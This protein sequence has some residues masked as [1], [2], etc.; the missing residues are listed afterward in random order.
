MQKL[1]KNFAITEFPE[2]GLFAICKNA[3]IEIQAFSVTAFGVG[4]YDFTK[5]LVSKKNQ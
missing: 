3:L 5:N 4:L 2:E 1:G